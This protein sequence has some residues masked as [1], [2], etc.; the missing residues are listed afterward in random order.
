M[1]FYNVLKSFRTRNV[2]TEMISNPY[3]SSIFNIDIYT[4]IE[5]FS[6]FLIIHTHL[7]LQMFLDMAV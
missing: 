1:N 7:F 5:V 6:G 4:Y 3:S 2:L